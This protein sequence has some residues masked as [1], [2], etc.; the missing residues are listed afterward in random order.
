MAATGEATTNRIKNYDLI[1]MFLA[2]PLLF[3]NFHRTRFARPLKLVSLLLFPSHLPASHIPNPDLCVRP[4]APKVPSR[5]RQ[6]CNLP[7]MST[8]HRFAPPNPGS[9]YPPNPPHPVPARGNDNA[10]VPLPRRD[11]GFNTLSACIK[12]HG[13]KVEGYPRST[14]VKRV[15]HNTPDDVVGRLVV[16]RPL[17][18]RH[19]GVVHPVVGHEE[20][21]GRAYDLMDLQPNL[22]FVDLVESTP[23]IPE[24]PGAVVGAGE[25]LD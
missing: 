13:T 2:I 14:W 1:P 4:T 24:T 19:G 16:P 7:N 9:I 12:R 15:P 23:C 6:S 20:P 25:Y 8:K 22:L 10:S 17:P 5:K 18:R 3:N 11:H 21:R